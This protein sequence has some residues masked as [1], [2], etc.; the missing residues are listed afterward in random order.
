MRNSSGFTSIKI[1]KFLVEALVLSKLSYCNVVYA[2][3]VIPT[4]I[5]IVFIMIIIVITIINI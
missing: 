4:T 1:R 2:H 5:I 3:V